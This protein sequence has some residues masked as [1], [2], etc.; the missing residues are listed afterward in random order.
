M[1]C[2]SKFSNA[3]SFAVNPGLVTR[4]DAGIVGKNDAIN[5]G[6]YSY[7][8]KATSSA[9][10]LSPLCQKRTS[11]TS[12]LSDQVNPL[13]SSYFHNHRFRIKKTS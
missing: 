4:I 3:G 1:K 10:H 2:R 8:L 7:S 12:Q 13:L 6:H 11:H 5:A 9:L